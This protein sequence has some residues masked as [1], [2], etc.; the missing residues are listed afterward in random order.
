MI[1]KEVTLPAA[2]DVQ[3]LEQSGK[4]LQDHKK[5]NL[6]N[7]FDSSYFIFWPK[8]TFELGL[9]SACFF[10]I[11]QMLKSFVENFLMQYTGACKLRVMKVK[12]FIS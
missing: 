8:K 5:S 6:L 1:N 4:D 7:I 10:C 3:A 11:I 2:A 9:K 12:G